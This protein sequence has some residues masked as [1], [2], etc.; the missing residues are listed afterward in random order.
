[1]SDD[2]FQDA[3]A[4]FLASDGAAQSATAT[5]STEL[6]GITAAR[7]AVHRNTFVATLVDMLAETFPV[8]LA[9]VGDDFFRAMARDCVLANPVR[10]AV[11]A[12]YA[13]EFPSFVAAYSPVASMPFIAELAQLEAMRLRAFHAADADPVDAAS[14]Q[15]LA[16]DARRL[17]HARVTLHPAAQWLRARHAVQSL[18]SAHDAADDMRSVDLS[19]LDVGVAQ[20]VLVH[21][22]GFELSV[23]ALPPGAADFLDAL[24]GGASLATA[25][26]QALAGDARAEPAA[27]FS[28]LLRQGLVAQLHESH[29]SGR[30]DDACTP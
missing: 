9:L 29:P 18:W 17:A 23:L 24:A 28:L 16:I 10:T 21:R 5:V 4:E 7:L 13:L 30:Q 14:F 25:F 3:F 26:A 6:A 15:P 12:E 19:S 1:M 20:D 2:R 8:T 11:L 27:L 22:R